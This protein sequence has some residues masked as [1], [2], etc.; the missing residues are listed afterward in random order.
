MKRAIYTPPPIPS[1][2]KLF[3][4]TDM[5]PVEVGLIE[6]IEPASPERVRMA[7]IIHPTDPDS[8]LGLIARGRGATGPL[9]GLERTVPAEQ[10]REID[11]D[12]TTWQS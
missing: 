5:G 1:Y 10:V 7:R 9:P 6:Y 11:A 4:F 2:M 8:V 12:E 3:G